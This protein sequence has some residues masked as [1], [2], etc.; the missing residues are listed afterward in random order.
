MK[1]YSY[2]KRE[3]VFDAASS[4]REPKSPV[5]KPLFTPKEYVERL[6][7]LIPAEVVMAFPLLKALLTTIPNP[8]VGM[9]VATFLAVGLTVFLRTIGLREDVRPQISAV[10]VSAIACLL[11]IYQ[12]GGF[13]IIAV[14][15]QYSNVT[16]ALVVVFSIISPYLVKGEK[17]VIL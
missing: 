1:I 2:V 4:A 5:E 13:F 8:S 16:L 17:K 11:W 7:L 12:Q 15:T 6:L 10:I 9:S 14:P 3:D